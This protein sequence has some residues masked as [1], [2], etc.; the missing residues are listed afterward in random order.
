MFLCMEIS[1]SPDKST[2]TLSQRISID[3]LLSRAKSSMKS[4]HPAPTP[5][6]AGFIFTK[7]D[8]PPIPQP[9]PARMPEIRG[10]IA[11]AEYIAY[12]T[13]GDIVFPVNKCCKYMAN[14]GDK[15]ID[16]FERVLRYLIGTRDYGL[17][18]RYDSKVPPLLAYS[19]S[20][21]MDCV[22][23][24]RST[25]AYLFFFCGNLVSWYSKLHTFVTTCS[26][27][28]EY[29]AMFQAAKEAQYLLNWLTPIL[30]F[31]G[32][33][34]TPIPI[35]N[36]NDGASALAK[37]PVGRFKNKHVLV[38]HH[39]T[40]ELVAANVIVPV[41]VD[42][43]ENKSDLLTKAL[44]PTVFPKLAVSLV[45]QIDNDVPPLILM[46]RPV[47]TQPQPVPRVCEIGTQCDFE[48]DLAHLTPTMYLPRTQV[49][50][51]ATCACQGLDVVPAP[52]MKLKQEH[53]SYCKRNGHSLFHCRRRSKD[54]KDLKRGRYD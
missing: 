3:N 26:N 5:C 31:L 47:R 6:V 8:C 11:L 24:S 1:Q 28:S 4:L 36:D 32:I 35:F 49:S 16:A 43:T 48:T 42:T 13:R 45:G 53:G 52:P 44:G 30:S 10:L 7:A 2:I 18:Y 19:D 23:T 34:V 15:H 33:T 37:D 54:H 50:A 22:D 25:L 20:S 9:R 39:Y 21:H 14:P 27:H 51:P 12:W 41:R 38:Q 29:A 40:Q 46:F 17:V